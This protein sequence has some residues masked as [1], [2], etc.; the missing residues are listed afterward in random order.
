MQITA[1]VT[2]IFKTVQRDRI[3][4]MFFKNPEFILPSAQ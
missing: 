1:D 2:T 3:F 4:N